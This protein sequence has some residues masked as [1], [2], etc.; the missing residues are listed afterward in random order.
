MSEDIRRSINLLESQVE[1]SATDLD[2][3][4]MSF[5]KSLTTTVGSMFSDVK[6]G[7]LQV[8]SAANKLFN[9]YKGYL[10]KIGHKPGT[11]EVGDIY[12]FLAAAGVPEQLIFAAISRGFSTAQQPVKIQNQQDLETWWNTYIK[13]DYKNKIGKV[14]LNITQEASRLPPQAIAPAAM[15]TRAQRGNANSQRAA[16]NAGRQQQP[17]QSAGGR[18]NTAPSKQ[19]KNTL[20]GKNNAAKLAAINNAIAALSA[21]PES[22]INELDLKGAFNKAKS[23]VSNK[24]KPAAS[25]TAATQP[26][27]FNTGDTDFDNFLNNALATQGK[28]ALLTVLNNYKS[29]LT[30]KND[31]FDTYKSEIRKL[32]GINSSRALPPNMAD[33]LKGDIAKLAKGDKESGAFAADKIMK[34]ARAGYDVQGLVTSWLTNAKV[35]ERFLNVKEWQEINEIL[36]ECNLS[37]ADIGLIFRLEESL[38]DTVIVSLLETST[39]GATS[40]GSIA[41]VLNSTNG[42]MKRMPNTP[43]LFGWIAPP[44]K[45]TKTQTKTE[46]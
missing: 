15:Q 13:T 12:S 4:P 24:V 16:R 25:T 29:K 42:I 10:G 43:N 3:A 34:Y 44:K 7:E 33:G 20:S 35:G 28:D 19:I 32:A 14:F 38:S 27:N 39:C 8:G 37:A 45:K 9:D 26:V 17:L 36:A 22:A 23:W 1:L 46:G 18:F 31:P 30:A 21:I 5:L 11:E 6:L 2:E 41:S 40:A